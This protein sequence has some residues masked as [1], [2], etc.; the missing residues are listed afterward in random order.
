[1]LAHQHVAQSSDERHNEREVP[2]GSDAVIAG[3]ST[4]DMSDDDLPV[5]DRSGGAGHEEEDESQSAN[6][7]SDDHQH[8]RSDAA[9]DDDD[10]SGWEAADGIEDGGCNNEDELHNELPCDTFP[11]ASNG[12]SGLDDEI[13]NSL[14]KEQVK[15]SSTLK[16]TNNVHNDGKRFLLALDEDEGIIGDYA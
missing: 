6:N 4:D 9:S 14:Q 12:P 16:P 8:A 7:A 13:L 1:M 10:T 2:I 15:S 5:P 3:E 11:G